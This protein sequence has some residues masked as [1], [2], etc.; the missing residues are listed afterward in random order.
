MSRACVVCGDSHG[1]VVF[2]EFG[3][4]VLRCHT[5]GHIYSTHETGQH[6]GEYFGKH[7][8][9]G[10]HFWWDEAHAR[11]HT[12]FCQR[13]LAGRGGTL[14]DVGCGLGFFVKRVSAFPHWRAFGC[15]T[16]KAA[17][18]FAQRELELKA[19]YWGPVEECDF[20]DRYFDIVTLW[21]VI[22]HVPDPDPLLSSVWN[23]LRDDGMLFMHTPN[24]SIQLPKARVTK[25]VR[26]MD[27]RLHYLEARD[28]VN[29]YSTDTIQ[30]VL[31][32]NGYG[33]IRF[34]HL[35]PIQSLAGN[36]SRFL[37]L[38][39]NVGFHAS[40]L[41]CKISLGRVNLDNLFVVARKARLQDA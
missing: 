27:P 5:C 12:D 23:L 35:H 33:D 15:D 19:I 13:F 6:H 25:L 40:R 7:V 34:V 29:L 3:V 32:R 41:L 18:E 4:E 9:A 39:K 37:A 10:D 22:E 14:L 38:L 31:H 24:V 1:S 21:D 26:G 16:S 11:M 8:P 28:H 30:R 2:E 17:V 20:S 36:R